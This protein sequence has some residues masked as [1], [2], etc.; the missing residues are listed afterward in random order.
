MADNTTTYKAVVDV[1]TTGLDNFNKLN[2]S[3]DDSLDGFE[4]L[5]AV[6]EKTRK[7]LQKAAIQGDKTEFKRLRKELNTMERQFEDVEIQSRRFSDALAEQPGIIG[8][9]GGSLKGLDGGL[10]VLAANPIIA[11]VTLLAGLFLAFKESLTKTAEGQEVL[12]RISGAFG[13]ILGPVFA[14]I[15]SVALP[16]FEKFADLLE[17]VGKGFNRFAR[18]LGISSEKIEEASI[19]SSEVLKT[20]ADEEIARQ[21]ELTKTTEENAQKRIDAAKKEADERLKI[22]ETAAAIQKEAELSLLSDKQREIVE[23]EAR[24][25]EELA[26][27]KLAGYTNFTALEEEYRQDLKDIDSKYKEEVAVVEDN[28]EEIRKEKEAQKRQ[29]ELA[30][31]EADFNL[32]QTL[33]ALKFEEELAFFDKSR[34]LQ[35]QELVANEA[36]NSALVAFD[37]ETAA[38]RTQIEEAQAQ[39][40]MA[41]ISDALGSLSSLVGEN[42]VAGKALAVA[43][44]VINTYQGATLAL[45]TYPPPFGA[46]AAGVTIAAGFAN[47]KKILSTKVPKPPGGGGGSSGGGSSASA[48]PPPSIAAPEIQTAGAAG[49]DVGSQIAETIAESS[50]KPV[51]AYVVSTE[52]SSVQSL[53][54]R[55]NNAATFG[56]G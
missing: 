39:T 52:V 28:S 14:L 43:Q 7:A 49:G 6:I 16:I 46:I 45:A 10:K 24:F 4:D 27:L 2:K 32:R 29:D 40:K 9:V 8:L 50:N 42:T 56:G 3:L 35:R 13:K 31:L 36:T 37:K 26:A 41:I 38:A 25:N 20:A 48:P 34:D 54:R 22:Q 12:N 30:F 47:V 1:E 18:F 51:Q 5:G 17:L 23:R 11:V 15:E 44:A 53:D 19:N 21:E 33:G 55:T